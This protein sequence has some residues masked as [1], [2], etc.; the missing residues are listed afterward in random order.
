MSDEKTYKVQQIAV[1][2]SGGT[3]Y[4]HLGKDVRA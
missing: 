4:R 1:T 2:P 3:V